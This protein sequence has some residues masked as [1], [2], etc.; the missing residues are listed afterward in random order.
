[1]KN[2]NVK[3]LT[4]GS[5]VVLGIVIYFYFSKKNK[6][7]P[8][9]PQTPERKPVK[10]TTWIMFKVKEGKNINLYASPNKN[11]RILKQLR[12]GESFDGVYFSDLPD[13]Y[14]TRY[15]QVLDTNAKPTQLIGYVSDE[16][17]KENY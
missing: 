4:F 7:T 11:G 9:T 6:K 16:F 14:G 5:F 3:I 12:S 15:I 13:F 2:N 10:W 17:V 8:Q 1:M